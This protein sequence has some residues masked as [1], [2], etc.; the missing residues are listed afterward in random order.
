MRNPR[1][2]SLRFALLYLTACRADPASRTMNGKTPTAPRLGIDALLSAARQNAVR[3]TD[4][5]DGSSGFGCGFRADTDGL[6]S[7]AKSLPGFLIIREL[8]RGGQ[9]IVYQCVREADSED[10]AI[11]ILR[12]RSIA[13]PRERDRFEREAAILRELNHPNVIAAQEVGVADGRPYLVM[14]YICGARLDEYV[15]QNALIV[16]A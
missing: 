10:V 16:S 12:D 14:P 15:S 6:E 8:H 13:S 4:A 5:R 11:K 3:L 2:R 9:G 1:K 7:I